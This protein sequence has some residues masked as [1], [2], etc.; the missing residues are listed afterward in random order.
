MRT[1][2]S[3]RRAPLL[4]LAVMVTMA[5]GSPAAL[6][7]SPHR[8]ARHTACA[9][10]STPSS[11]ASRAA[12]R[13]AVVCLINRQRSA[14]GLPALVEDKRLDHSAQAWTDTMVATGQFSHGIDFAARI[15]AAGYSWSS[16]GE[17]I[18]TG[19]ATPAQVVSAWMH[20]YAHC[21]NILDPE[22]RS[23]GTGIVD[24]AIEPFSSAPA[25]WTQ[26]FALPVGSQSPSGNW[27]PAEKVC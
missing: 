27:G 3:C 26:D 15:S 17:N 1:S 25:T 22:Y 8:H 16:A 10:A 19:F 18:A 4:T 14:V 13:A 6:A 20:S 2:T 9:H 24:Q 21:R 11:R 7:A 12:I 23:V 5:L